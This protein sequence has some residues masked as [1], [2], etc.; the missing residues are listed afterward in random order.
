MDDAPDLGARRADPACVFSHSACGNLRTPRLS[1]GKGNRVDPRSSAFHAGS[2]SREADSGARAGAS[3]NG[4]HDRGALLD[5]LRGLFSREVGQERFARFFDQQTRMEV[6][7]NVVDVTVPD[8]FRRD[9]L[10]RRFGC[11]L[12]RVLRDECARSGQELELRFQV[13]GGAFGPQGGSAAQPTTAPQA[14]RSSAKGVAREGGRL[15]P[16]H[17]FDE[18]VVG[19][20]NQVAYAAAR[21][22]A[23]EPTPG[24]CSPLFIHGACGLGKTHLLQSVV[25]RFRELQPRARVLYVTGESFTNEFVLAVRSGSMDGF[26]KVYRRVNLLC[27]DDLHFVAGKEATQTEL[28]H[29]LDAIGVDRARII[30]ASDA[31]PREIRKFSSA[32]VSRLVAGAVV[33]LDPPDLELRTRV[34]A[35]LA[36]Q[37]GLPLSAG[38]ARL[39]AECTPSGSNGP[40]SVRDVEGMLT[41]IEA[42][43]NLLPDL[44]AGDG[45]IGAVI[46]R[47]ALEMRRQG[48]GPTRDGQRGRPIPIDAI[49]KV[50]CHELEVELSDFLGKV[51]HERVVLARSL[52]VY[53]SREITTRSYPEIASAMKRPNHSSVV[54]AFTRIAKKIQ[55]GQ[56]VRGGGKYDG[57]TIG[58]VADRLIEE[59]RRHAGS[60]G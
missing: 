44:A 46:V 14:Q 26:R 28:L 53:I 3:S 22:V 55:E 58:V 36:M 51:R 17:R 1:E 13:D 49:V 37:R 24:A 34:V 60:A 57:L 20:A 6:E 42:V 56:I 15:E 4:R 41:Q 2:S 11:D 16:K 21:R 7:G 8:P 47:N 31:H 54:S 18:F 52:A 30:M 25:H 27:I 23:E 39:I 48:A 33:R 32:L 50:V 45:S 19:Q 9:L 40:A 12:R 29:T 59:V 10:E 43:W 38:T 35:Q 5:H